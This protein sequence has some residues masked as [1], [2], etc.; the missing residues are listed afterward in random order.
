M[1]NILTFSLL[2]LTSYFAPQARATPSYWAAVETTAYSGDKSGGTQTSGYSAYY[3]TV[4][5][6]QTLFGGS[7]VEA[8][9]SYVK[10][11]FAEVKGMTDATYDSV[12]YSDGEYQILHYVDKAFKSPEYVAVAF[13]GSEAYRVYGY[14]SG[15]GGSAA[16]TPYGQLAFNESYAKS[17]MVGDW[18][19]VP[20]P[21]SGL[22]LLLSVAGLALRRKR[23]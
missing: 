16:L 20:E 7:T 4:D 1:K 11:H 17:G 22:L 9:E 15:V 14:E 6:A 18:Q 21:T 13:Y 8:I 23:T 10:S 19:T 3:C 12:D 5:A 2:L